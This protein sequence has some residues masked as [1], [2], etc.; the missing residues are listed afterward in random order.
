MLD[1]LYRAQSI[2]DINEIRDELSSEGYIRTQTKG[3]KVK[4]SFNFNEYKSVEG[5][6]IL[7]GKSNRQNDILTTKLADK[8]DMWFHTKNIPGSHVIVFCSGKELSKE[9]IQFAA[10]LAASNSRA[11]N[12]GSVPVDYTP[13]KY[14]KR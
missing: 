6:K 7:V 4:P 12:S 10:N 14:V 2:S 3:S 8:S 5:Y 9:T 11:K 1:S 13:V